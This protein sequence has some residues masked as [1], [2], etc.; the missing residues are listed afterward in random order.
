MRTFVQEITK[1][2]HPVATGE[3]DHCGRSDSRSPSYRKAFR[4]HAHSVPTITVLQAISEGVEMPAARAATALAAS[5][6][7]FATALT[8]RTAGLP[9][10]W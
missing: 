3:L 5:L 9:G 1:Q 10:A 2:H 8:T 6:L 7:L 4:R